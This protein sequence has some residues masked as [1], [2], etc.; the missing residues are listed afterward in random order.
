MI[1][2]ARGLGAQPQLL[3]DAEH[4]NTSIFPKLLKRSP[5]KNSRT[6]FKKATKHTKD[7]TL[8]Y[9]EQNSDGKKNKKPP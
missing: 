4:E 3:I 9:R 6:S 5:F 1:L 7:V 8:P 2:S